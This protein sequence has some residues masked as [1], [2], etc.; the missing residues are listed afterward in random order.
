MEIHNLRNQY[1]EK[2]QKAKQNLFHKLRFLNKI[3][4]QFKQIGGATLLLEDDTTHK[5]EP[6]PLLLTN[7][8]QLKTRTFIM[9]FNLNDVLVNTSTNI[10][11]T[12]NNFKI[13]KKGNILYL[14]NAQDKPL[15]KLDNKI[16]TSVGEEIIPDG[17]SDVLEIIQ[18][19]CVEGFYEILLKLE[20]NDSLITK[21]EEGINTKMK[22]KHDMIDKLEKELKKCQDKDSDK[23]V[24]L[25]QEIKKLKDEL[26][27]IKNCNEEK[28]KAMRDLTQRIEVQ[29]I[30]LVKIAEN[31]DQQ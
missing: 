14:E 5:N 30:N 27:K 24:D 7:N 22:D 17:T 31:L 4:Q 20:A 3:D 26:E 19:N 16:I 25:E 6:K 11:I 28:E 29:N 10:P 18:D 15:Q 23:C 9:N 8:I 2:I 13:L 21:I 12:F 1:K